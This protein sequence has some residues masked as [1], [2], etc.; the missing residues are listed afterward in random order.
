MEIHHQAEMLHLFY[1]QAESFP[2]GITNAF[3]QLYELMQD[4]EQRSL[5]GISKPYQ[6]RIVYWAG[7]LEK[8]PKEGEQY[9]CN[10][11]VLEAGDYLS[12]TIIN[13]NERVE[14]IAITFSEL[15]TD[16][17]LDPSAYCIEWYKGDDLTCMVKIKT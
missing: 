17:R 5:F 9:G 1:V 14:E 2:Q 8:Y 10:T 6:N 12:K 16:E 15:L 13:W 4:K 11:F 7:A 3:D